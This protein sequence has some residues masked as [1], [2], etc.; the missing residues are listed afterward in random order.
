MEDR[1][2]RANARGFGGETK[3]RGEQGGEENNTL[4]HQMTVFITLWHF[5]PSFGLDQ[6]SARGSRGGSGTAF[7]NVELDRLFPDP[8]ESGTLLDIICHLNV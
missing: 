5:L 6:R 3:A 8:R 4:S 7:W 1:I 2:R